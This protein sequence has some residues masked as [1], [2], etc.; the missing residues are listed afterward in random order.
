MP[1]WIGMALVLGGL[2]MVAVV[3]WV[4][5]EARQVPGV[6]VCHTCDYMF[7]DLEGNGRCDNCGSANQGAEY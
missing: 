2:C 3:D 1:E 5:A 6:I 4:L 7:Y